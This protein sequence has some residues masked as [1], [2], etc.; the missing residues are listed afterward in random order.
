MTQDSNNNLYKDKYIRKSRRLNG[1]DYSY[2]GWYFVTICT[3]DHELL[4]GKIING[5]MILNKYG[6]IAKEEWIKSE[7]I[8]KE[9]ELNDFVIMP[10][11]FHALIGIDF[12]NYTEQ[13]SNKNYGAARRFPKSISSLI[14]GFKGS[15]TRKI[16]EVN[17][18]K[19]IKI[20]QSNY[21]DHIIRK[22]ELLNKVQSYI[23][24]NPA[25]WERDKYHRQM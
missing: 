15:V 4:F 10:N 21:Y 20:W 23:K 5:E 6:L 22:E 18:T 11:H 1:R 7:S 19:G 17:N 12:K 16:N 2:P 24:N 14:S 13:E 9:I 8:R 25:V 3:Y